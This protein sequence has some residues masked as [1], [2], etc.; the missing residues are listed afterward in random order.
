M[1]NAAI[2]IIY[3]IPE[4]H[5]MKIRFPKIGIPCLLFIHLYCSPATNLAEGD[6]LYVDVS[7]ALNVRTEPSADSVIAGKAYRGDLVTVL[8]VASPELMIDGRTGHWV[9]VSIENQ[10]A[11]PLRGYVFSGFLSREPLQD[12][13]SSDSDLASHLV[14]RGL[15]QQLHRT[16]HDADR[17]SNCQPFS[18]KFLPTGQVRND[19]PGLYYEGEWQRNQESIEIQFSPGNENAPGKSAVIKATQLPNVVEFDLTKPDG[20]NAIYFLTICRDQ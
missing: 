18:L 2:G 10:Q 19:E 13:K 5:Q 1:R 14:N 7:T 16:V 12:A 8:D 3:T 9:H 15:D 11:N 6:N 17:N 4:K 20:S